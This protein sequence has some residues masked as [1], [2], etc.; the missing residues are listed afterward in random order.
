[1]TK[2]YIEGELLLFD[3]PYEWTSFDLVNKIRVKLKYALRKKNIKV[4]HAGTLD[5]LATGLMIVCTG[6]ATKRIDLLSGLDKEYIATIELG[7]T[8][9]T[10]DLE[11]MVDERFAV[12][13]ITPD[14]LNE[15]LQRFMG[16]IEQMPPIFSAIKIKGEKAYELARRGEK[17]E[18]KPRPITI[19]ALEVLEFNMPKLVLRVHCSKGTYIRS[20]AHDLGKALGSGGHL[21]GLIRTRIGEFSL[22]QAQ[23]IEKFVRNLQSVET[24]G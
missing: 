4:G 3:K 1:M 14:L 6:K 20:L 8:T 13:H 2:D 21:T 22:E 12:D 23:E 10:Y 11:S 15:T 17:I 9:P 24:N 16:D 18:L 5:P 19:F 7:A